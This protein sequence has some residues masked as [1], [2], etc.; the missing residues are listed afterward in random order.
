[1]QRS[2]TCP[3]ALIRLRLPSCPPS[4]RS[5]SPPFVFVFVFPPLIQ[6]VSILEQRLSLTEDKLKECLENQIEMGLHLQRQEEEEE[7][8]EGLKS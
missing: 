7:E 2:V 4:R 8:D 5:S 3:V 6:T 1:M